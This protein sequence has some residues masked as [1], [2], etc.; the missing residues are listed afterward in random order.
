[1][2]VLEKFQLSILKLQ[3][4]KVAAIERSIYTVSIG[5]IDYS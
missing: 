3:P 4:Y 5:K 2:Y 1:M